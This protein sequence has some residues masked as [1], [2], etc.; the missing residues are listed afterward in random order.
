MTAEELTA[1]A[2]RAQ[3]GDDAAR[4]ELLVALYRD[5]RKHVYFTVGPGAM[6]DDVVQEAMI[7][8]DRG[9]GEFRGDTATLRVDDA[10]GPARS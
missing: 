4:D 1:L 3:A 7:A 6:A 9:L 8:A 5:V 10:H 2:K